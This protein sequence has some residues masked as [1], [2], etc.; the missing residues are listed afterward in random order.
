MTVFP[1]GKYIL[2]IIM[3]NS[4]DICFVVKVLKGPHVSL[5]V[6]EI[7]M[8]IKMTEKRRKRKR[9]TN[10]HANMCITVIAIVIHV[11]DVKVGQ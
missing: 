5:V 6:L 9:Q 8:K 10:T 1:L 11:S 4:S 3:L 2:I 7:N